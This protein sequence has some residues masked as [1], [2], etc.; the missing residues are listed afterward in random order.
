MKKVL[1]IVDYQ[2]DFV[3]G[4]LG[5]EKAKYLCTPIVEKINLYKTTGN[6]VIYTFDLHN[7]DYLNTLEGENLP[8]KHCIKDTLGCKLYGEVENYF[9]KN[10]DVYFEKG[11][12]GSL[13]LANYLAENK[14]DEVEFVG[15]VSNI[16]VLSNAVLARA[17]LPN[18]QII[19]DANCTASHDQ[20]MN[21]KALDILQ[22]LHIKVINR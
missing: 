12:F 11:T 3:C 2:N 22:G 19:V 18:S 10:K 8:I 21:E 13:E 14:Y 16:C 5:F 6:D 17:A 4:S 15:L 1:V 9:D 20:S 7:D